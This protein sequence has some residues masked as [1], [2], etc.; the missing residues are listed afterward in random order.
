M[1][2]FDEGVSMN[3]IEEAKNLVENLDQH[4]APSPYDIAWMARV[5]DSNGAPR[6]P[7]MVKWLLDHQH[8]DGS[9]GGEIEYY[10]DR[11]ICTLTTI[12]ALQENRHFKGSKIA[13]QRGEQYLWRNLHL[14]PRD[15]FELVGFELIV[16]T[17]LGEAQRVGLDVPDHA[18]GYGDIQ[19][20]KLTLIPPNKLYSPNLSTVFS[21]EFMGRS[22]DIAK[23]R[24][25]LNENGSIGNS[26]ATT[27]YYLELNPKDSRAKLYLE[28]VVRKKKYGIPVYPFRVFELTWVLNNLIFS[29]IPI[30][31]FAGEDI[32]EELRVS[33]G[34][35][36]VGSDTT[37]I[38]DGDSTSVCCHVLL[39]SGYDIPPSIPGQYEDKAR[40]LFRTYPYE[41][42]ISISTN[43]HALDALRS[44]PTYPN[45]E[46]LRES[47]ILMLLNNREYNM[48]WVD[49]W[50]ASPYYATSHALVAL[51]KEK[52]N[53]LIHACRH[54]IDWLI[55]N[56]REDGSWGFFDR[57]TPEETAYVLT[58]LL[59]YYQQESVN[60][61]IL[62]RAADYLIEAH[63]EDWTP[64]PL[65]II[66]SLFLPH[67]IVKSAILSSLI[68]YQK[69]VSS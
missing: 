41:R 38:P 67:N 40:K 34:P 56:Q 15:P 7:E 61:E 53:Y 4:M 49:K 52:K 43:V 51:L 26:P 32:W 9:W 54:T 27:A 8:P 24:T 14:L 68:L 63:Q 30:T 33:L 37:F 28:D 48:Y 31:E 46:K 58:A 22:G 11:I 59:H 1:P 13:V 19:T 44:M 17:L 16:P 5:K 10:H 6:W 57:G 18:C 3:Y 55:H 47:I 50:H 45:Q 69:T 21:L 65:W 29:S 35:R 39:Q 20:K 23:L 25:A 64:P 2:F 12:I 42:N 62:H 60:L 36:G 66:K